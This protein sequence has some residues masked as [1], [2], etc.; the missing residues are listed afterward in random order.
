ME[1]IFQRA[2][3]IMETLQK[4]GYEAYFVGG[5]VRD[6]CMKRDIGDIDI[7]T[8][9]TPNEIISIFPKT[10]DVGAKHG[11]IIVFDQNNESY[12][13]T[14]FRTESSYS[15]NRRPDEVKWGKSIIDDL[16]RRDFT[17]NAMAIA[18]KADFL[19]EFFTKN[20]SDQNAQKHGRKGTDI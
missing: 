12:E 3:P 13:I 8:S 4:N 1:P 16:S 14:T 10:V 11:T 2:I 7:A 9:A 5:S 15:D 20:F 17:I 6:F 19:D 18:V